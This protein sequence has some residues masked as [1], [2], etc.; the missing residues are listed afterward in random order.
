MTKKIYQSL[1]TIL[2]KIYRVWQKIHTK[3]LGDGLDDASGSPLPFLGEGRDLDGVH[4]VGGQVLELVPVLSTGDHRLVFLLQIGVIVVHPVLLDRVP[5]LTRWLPRD[6]DRVWSGHLLP[7]V[8]RLGR[9]WNINPTVEILC[10]WLFS[11]SL[12]FQFILFQSSM[13]VC[14]SI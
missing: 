4:C 11:L 14:S 5:G 10:V 6:V 2:Y 12:F 13:Y 9:N 8:T 1:L 3:V 7:N